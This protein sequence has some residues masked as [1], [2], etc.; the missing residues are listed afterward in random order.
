MEKTFEN[1][2]ELFNKSISKDQKN[3]LKAITKAIYTFI[4]KFF[5][6]LGFLDGVLGLRLALINAAYTYKKY[7]PTLHKDS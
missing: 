4:F 2:A 5:I 7:R 1:Y 3:N 6:R